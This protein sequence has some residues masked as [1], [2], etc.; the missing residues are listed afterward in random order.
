MILTNR[1]IVNSVTSL[2]TLSDLKLPAKVSYKFGRIISILNSLLESYQAALSKLQKEYAEKN[3]DGSVKSTV[4][5]DK[6]T[7][8]LT[9]V[10]GFQGEV[11]ELL[12]VENDVNV[13]QISVGD[14]GDCNVEPSVFVPLDWLFIE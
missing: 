14:L 7:F 4:D 8:Q 5:G 6:T 3:E 12:D 1:Q 13:R 10:V 11:R 9:D 2:K